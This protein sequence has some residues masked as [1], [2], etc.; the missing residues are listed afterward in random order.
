MGNL[1]GDSRPLHQEEVRRL[2]KDNSPAAKTVDFSFA[3]GGEGDAAAESSSRPHW[4]LLLHRQWC[5]GEL[6]AACSMFQFDQ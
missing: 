3:L 2:E 4:C 5:C 1:P 6:S